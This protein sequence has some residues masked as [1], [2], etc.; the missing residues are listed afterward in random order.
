MIIANNRGNLLDHLNP[1]KLL[2]VPNSD[3][4]S[5]LQIYR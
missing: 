3:S 5:E 1:T 2:V 4:Y